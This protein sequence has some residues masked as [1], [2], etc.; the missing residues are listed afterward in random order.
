M[1]YRG[2]LFLKNRNTY[3]VFFFCFPFST[4]LA[5]KESSDAL[6]ARREVNELATS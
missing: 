1:K 6:K 5:R 3:S 4:A 2:D